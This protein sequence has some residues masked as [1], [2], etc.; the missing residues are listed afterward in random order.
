V[1]AT[2][3][4][5][6]L[7]RRAAH[8]VGLMLSEEAGIMNVSN[9]LAALVIAFSCAAV[10]AHAKGC[11][12]GAVVGGVAGHYAGHH[13]VLG[14]IAGCAIGHHRAKE[15]E[16]ERSSDRHGRPTSGRWGS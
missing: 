4:R 14:A 16:R 6:H 3:A 13:A 10:P 1:R 12:K 8:R 7:E 9:R 11:I 5:K 15:R 2:I